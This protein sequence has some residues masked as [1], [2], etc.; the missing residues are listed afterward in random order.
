MMQSA[1]NNR[2]I[3][4]V[5][6]PDSQNGI[7]RGLLSQGNI[8]LASRPTVQNQDGS[9]STVRS[10]SV[11]MEIGGK[12]VQ[13]LVPTVS[14]DGRIMS[15]E[16]AIETFRRTGRHLGMFDTP[17]NATIYALNLHNQQDKMYGRGR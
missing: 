14:D 7:P 16:E 4:V 5:Q 13:V 1:Q 6:D 17:E 3:F 9:I 10:L 15:D 11:G 12:P 2:P 8:D